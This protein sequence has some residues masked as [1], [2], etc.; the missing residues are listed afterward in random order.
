MLERGNVSSR[1][2]IS[3]ETISFSTDSAF[4]ERENREGRWGE[5]YD[6]VTS[7][8]IQQ[9]PEIDY[10]CGSDC[11]ERKESDH[12][13]RD[14]QGEEDTSQEHP[15]PPRF[16]EFSDEQRI[17]KGIQSLV[18]EETSGCCWDSRVPKFV[19]TSVGVECEAHEEDEG[20]VEEDQPSLGNVSVV[21]KRRNH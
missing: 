20:G 10:Y 19:E 6:T 12:L 15:S 5:T 1:V 11:E 21:W 18:H 16:R 14:R 4:V 7:F 2:P 8:D 3:S 17:S 13:A 9:V